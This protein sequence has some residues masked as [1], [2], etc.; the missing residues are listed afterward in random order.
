MYYLVRK[1]TW[2]MFQY[3][4][5]QKSSKKLARSHLH[6]PT[7]KYIYYSI[8]HEKVAYDPI[9]QYIGENV[10]LKLK[11][12]GQNPKTQPRHMFYNH[13]CQKSPKK[14][15]K[16]PI[17]SKIMVQGWQST[18][19]LKFDCCILIVC[20]RRIINSIFPIFTL[21]NDEM[22]VKVP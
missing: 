8:T 17:H 22:Q 5:S 2:H 1:H 4:L 19:P 10:P 21:D 14:W 6:T 13:F 12:R 20:K 7:Y 18:D 9:F 15:E 11:I 16:R 3:H